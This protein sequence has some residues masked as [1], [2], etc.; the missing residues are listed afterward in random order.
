MSPI[1]LKSQFNSNGLSIS[2][3]TGSRPT[4]QTFIFLAYLLPV[5]MGTLLQVIENQSGDFPSVSIKSI[6][7]TRPIRR[8]NLWFSG[9]FREE[10]SLNDEFAQKD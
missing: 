9:K 2:A 7:S 3:H 6:S 10:E 4:L 1:T 5:T 8:E